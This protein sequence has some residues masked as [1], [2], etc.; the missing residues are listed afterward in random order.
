MG[1]GKSWDGVENQLLAQAWIAASEDVFLGADQKG[2]RFWST[3]HSRFCD[4]CPP[5]SASSEGRFEMRSLLSC[6]S[7]FSELSRDCQKFQKALRLVNISNP[8]GCT[9]ENILSMA[10]AVHLQKTTRMDY[11]FK[12]F[13]KE[14][15]SYFRAW[16]VLHTSPKWE[17][18]STQ[19]SNVHNEAPTSEEP[20]N[21]PRLDSQERNE[22]EDNREDT[23]SLMLTDS[24]S[25][26]PERFSFGTKAAKL[27]RQ[28]SL[29][30]RAVQSMAESA[31]RKSDALEERN[32]IAVFSRKEAEGLP[33]T[34]Q[35]FSALRKIHLD[36]ALKR[37]RFIDRGDA[38]DSD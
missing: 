25:Q 2:R 10:V 36:K 6:K 30:T 3:L 16:Q 1:R 38:R 14:T 17:T 15:W 34:E 24:R 33:E 31:K 19:D 4:F 29:R 28:E 11:E 13:C 35:Y 32:A 22:Q 20:N 8:T 23:A 26:T 9:E 21:A 7:H 37:A 27:M 18:S 12:T 5:P